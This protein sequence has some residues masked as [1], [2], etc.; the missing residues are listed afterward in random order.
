VPGNELIA[1]ISG[2]GVHFVAHV[3]LPLCMRSDCNGIFFYDD[4]ND[5]KAFLVESFLEGPEE[6]GYHATA[7]F[8]KRKGTI[9]IPSS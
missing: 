6:P 4:R 7:A 5:G 2:N 8:Y 1:V 9:K 3:K